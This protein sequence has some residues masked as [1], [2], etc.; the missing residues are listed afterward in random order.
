MRNYLQEQGE[1][2][3]LLFFCLLEPD[4]VPALRE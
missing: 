2:I 1:M 4:S 3:S